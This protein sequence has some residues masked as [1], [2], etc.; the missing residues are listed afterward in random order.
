MYKSLTYSIYL[1][2]C[3]NSGLTRVFFSR[4]Y[5]P[6]ISTIK[7]MVF[8][9]NI[10]LMVLYSIKEKK[11]LYLPKYTVKTSNFLL[12]LYRTFQLT[13]KN[14]K[15]KIKFKHFTDK[16]GYMYFQKNVGYISKK[17]SFL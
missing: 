6:T 16:N 13:L 8:V 7:K 1:R 9:E 11:K 2:I 3:A 12:L 17:L 15:R 14:F 4:K 5:A 10:A